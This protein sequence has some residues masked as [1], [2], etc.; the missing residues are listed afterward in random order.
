[1]IEL[2]EALRIV[3]DAARPLR[4][5][6]V[7][8]GDALGR[9]LAQDVAADMDQQALGKA[10]IEQVL[11]VGRVAAGL[12]GKGSRLPSSYKG[13]SF[14]KSGPESRPVSAARIG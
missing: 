11:E 7:E 13:I 9:I 8:L 2:K 12:R 6:R 4:T 1:M 5:E 10:N 3:S 14:S